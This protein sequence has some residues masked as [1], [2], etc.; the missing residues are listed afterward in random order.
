MV[1]T[2]HHSKE[3]VRSL[4]TAFRLTDEQKET[5]RQEAFWKYWI[6]QVRKNDNPEAWD[7]QKDKSEGDRWW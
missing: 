7:D 1:M 6:D 3:Y 4:I 2:M 5:R